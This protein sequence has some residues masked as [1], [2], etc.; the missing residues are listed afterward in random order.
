VRSKEKHRVPGSGEGRVRRNAIRDTGGDAVQLTIDYIKQ[1]ALG[2]LKATGRFVAAGVA[3]T[4]LLS[5][6]TILLLVGVLRLLQTETGTALTGDWSW[7]PYFV[8]AIIAVAIVA[9]AG[10]RIT[11]GP[12]TPRYPVVAARQAAAAAPGPATW[13]ATPAATPPPPPPTPP[14]PP[15][16]PGPAGQGGPH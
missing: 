14:P 2:P 1:E 15:P 4:T 3:A 16:P 8:I 13:P 5:V 11:A 10:W 6:G 7:V 12:A 9:L